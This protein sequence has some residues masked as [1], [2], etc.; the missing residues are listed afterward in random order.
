MD[1]LTLGVEAVSFRT[2]PPLGETTTAI[3]EIVRNCAR[4]VVLRERKV[5]GEVA[6]ADLSTDRLM[7]L[8]AEPYET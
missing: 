1:A 2:P 5:A 8:M 4:V 3:E 7:H 6:A